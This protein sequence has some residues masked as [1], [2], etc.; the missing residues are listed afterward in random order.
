MGNYY[1]YRIGQSLALLL[2]LPLAYAL[3]DVVADI[4]C[5]FAAGDRRAVKDNL[6]VIFPHMAEKEMLQTQRNMT[7]N[8]AKYL[9]EFFRFSKID[10][11]YIK[12]NV[13]LKNLSY[14]QDALAKGKGAIL[15]TAHMGNWE[16]GAVALGL[17]KFP[18]LAVALEHKDARVNHLFVTQRQEKGIVVVPLGKAALQCLKRIKQNMAIALVGDRDFTEKGIVLD[19]FGK[20]AIFPEGPA[21]FSLLTGAPVIPCF[22]LR[23]KGNSFTF[24][25]ESP[26]SFTPTGNK[27]KDK[28]GIITTYKKLFEDYIRAYPDQWLMFRKF[29]IDRTS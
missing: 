18:I 12:K 15:L 21:V 29:W 6:A 19:F 20:P 28:T 16:L 4:Y 23:N 25:F 1:F 7:R 8:F 5:F 14:L 2:P 10:L 17:L 22:V 26:L 27:E 24:T 13:T 11:A 3:A 9:V